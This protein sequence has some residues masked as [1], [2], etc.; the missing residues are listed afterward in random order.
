MNNIS[1]KNIFLLVLL[2]YWTD[3]KAQT[4]LPGHLYTLEGKIVGSLKIPP[5][6]GGF[7]FATIIEFKIIKFSDSTY[8]RKYIPIIFPCPETYGIDFLNIG[9]VY[10]IDIGDNYPGEASYL[11]INKK[12][13]SKYHLEKKF[14]ALMVKKE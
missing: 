4:S 3:I 14:W 8:S 10:H 1:M 11:L 13:L 9:K 6:C 5:A 12:V 2:F 7:T